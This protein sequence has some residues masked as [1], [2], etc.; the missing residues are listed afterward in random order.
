MRI[1][2]FLRSKKVVNVCTLFWSVNLKLNIYIGIYIA[3][4][5]NI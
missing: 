2:A 4:D 1:V 5:V 3:F